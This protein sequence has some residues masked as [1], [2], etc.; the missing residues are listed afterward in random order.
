MS[1]FEGTAFNTA[2]YG[3]QFGSYILINLIPTIMVF[4]FALAITRNKNHLQIIQLPLAL[5]FLGAGVSTGYIPLVIYIIL[6]VTQTVNLSNLLDTMS[7][8]IETLRRPKAQKR[9]Y[10][11]NTTTIHKGPSMSQIKKAIQVE[12]S[13]STKK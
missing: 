6:F 12:P 9:E 8:T 4:V 3:L 1:G 5:A 10:T 13:E 7:S 2:I 11:N